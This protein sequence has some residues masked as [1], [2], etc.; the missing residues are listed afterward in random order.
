MLIALQA[1][2]RDQKLLGYATKIHIKH[3]GRITQM[4][5]AKEVL[6]IREENY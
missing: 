1:Q 6:W 4:K 5:F 3:N 2:M